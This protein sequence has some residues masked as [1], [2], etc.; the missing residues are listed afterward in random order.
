MGKQ[1]EK[2]RFPSK[3]SHGKFVTGA[4]YIIEL[5]CENKADRPLPQKFWQLP[6]HQQFYKSQTR[7]VH[8]LLKKYDVYLL[9]DF[10]KTNKYIKSLRPK[11]VHEKIEEFAKTWKPAVSSEAEPQPTAKKTRLTSMKKKKSAIHELL[12]E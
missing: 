3:Y 11:W 8:S 2:S 7:A 1:T 9:I 10:V 4:Q 12:D 5:I 6:E